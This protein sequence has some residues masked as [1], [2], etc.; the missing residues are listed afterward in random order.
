MLRDVQRPDEAIDSFR[1]ALEK[2]GDRPDIL[3]TLGYALQERGELD[4]ALEV[5]NKSISAHSDPGT[6]SN[7][8]MVMCYHPG[9]T[10]QKHFEAHRAFAKLHEDPLKPKWT[11][12]E[13]SRDPDRRLKVGYFS[14]DLR[15]HVVSYFST[16]IFE[17]HAH[18]NFEIF[19]YS[20]NHQA[21]AMT[22][23]Q[24]TKFDKWRETAGMHPD[25][26]AEIIRADG[27]DILI[28]LAGHTG[29]NGMPVLMRKPAPIQINAIGFP[30]TT[31]LTSVDYRITDRLCDPPGMAEAHNS[32]KLL[33]MPDCFWVLS[34]AHGGDRRRPAAGG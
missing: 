20:N 6:H 28:E 27:I 17:N 18:D 31:G 13:N 14:P 23:I 30:S 32:E 29:G 25:K 7:V 26:I 34:A 15:G 24:H 21:D 22:I 5:L 12:H 9:V 8:M 16:P 2:V 33:Y 19:A 11:P 10:P 4:E 1:S 3:A